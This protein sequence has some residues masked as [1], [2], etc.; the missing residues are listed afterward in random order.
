MSLDPLQVIGLNDSDRPISIRQKMFYLQDL[1]NQ[2]LQL[3][4][5]NFRVVEYMDSA[6][7]SSAGMERDTRLDLLGNPARYCAIE[8]TGV[9]EEVYEEHATFTDTFTL[10]LL[11]GTGGGYSDPLDQLVF[12][13]AANGFRD[14]YGAEG[15]WN[16]VTLTWDEPPGILTVLRRQ[17]VI[18][19]TEG[20]P[21]HVHDVRDVERTARPITIDSS[22]PD[23]RYELSA[24]VYLS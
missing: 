4:D 22:T 14:A 7:M 24:T 8:H 12:E 6:I 17:I 16:D 5:P 10:T 19:R 21:I 23:D 11:Y 15:V 20:P 18:P 13:T 3:H 9:S 2:V 1:L